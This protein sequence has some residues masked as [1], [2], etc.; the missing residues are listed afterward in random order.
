MP[1]GGFSDNAGAAAPRY[2]CAP[3]V[4]PA[5]SDRVDSSPLA[6]HTKVRFLVVDVLFHFVTLQYDCFFTYNPIIPAD[7]KSRRERTSLRNLSLFGVLFL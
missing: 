4:P 2:R 7:Y 6:I 3:P 5:V 1:C